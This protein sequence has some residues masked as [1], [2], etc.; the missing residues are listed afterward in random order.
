M[1]PT[2]GHRD[3]AR[4]VI[5]HVVIINIS[6][7]PFAT[8]K[9]QPVARCCRACLAQ[10]PHNLTCC[11]GPSLSPLHVNTLPPLHS[12]LV[13]P[14]W[15]L[16]QHFTV[17]GPLLEAEESRRRPVAGCPPAPPMSSSSTRTPPACPRG[18]PAPVAIAMQVHSRHM[19]VVP[20]RT[21]AVRRPTRTTA[22]SRR[23]AGAG[24]PLLLSV[25]GNRRRVTCATTTGVCRPACIYRRIV[26]DYLHAS[27]PA[28]HSP[29]L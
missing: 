28:L 2:A 27:W 6:V 16:L 10:F 20:P 5:D 21:A 17:A 3:T 15:T 22:A 11:W 9:T 18:I 25:S 24:A 26:I 13:C 12:L 19:P 1:V 4:P 29:S 23:W 14:W 8:A 7:P